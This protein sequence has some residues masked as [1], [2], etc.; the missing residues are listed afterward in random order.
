MKPI[1]S[2][3]PRPEPQKVLLSF[4]SNYVFVCILTLVLYFAAAFPIL[5]STS[6]YL[7]ASSYIENTE[8]AAGFTLKANL[9]YEPYKE[10]CEN[11]YLHSY[12][13][14]LKEAYNEANSTSFT[15]NH[16][17]NILVLRL[18]V[19]PSPSDY[20]TDYF[21]YPL[22]EDGTVNA[23]GLGLI[24]RD[25]GSRG[26]DDVRDIYYTGYSRIQDNLLIFDSTYAK[27]KGD[28]RA[29]EG[30][31]RFACLSFSLLIVEVLFPFFAKFGRRP[32]EL[33][34]KVC[35]LNRNGFGASFYKSLLRALIELLL[36]SIGIYYLN[37]YFVTLFLVFPYFIEGITMLFDEYNRGYIERILSLIPADFK[38]EKIYANEA[39]ML[40]D[41][42]NSLAAYAE[43]GYTGKLSEVDS[44][45]S[46]AEGK[47]S[48]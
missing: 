27:A 30:A 5:H 48:N 22:N 18:P 10:A 33:I 8:V 9:S 19:S 44:F 39:E 13:E 4:L 36:A 14:E 1:R 34:F 47:K 32:G 16:I 7:S 29:M 23:D 31:S 17:Y 21:A 35:Y 2:G 28:I 41:R 42:E 11:F 38:A 6:S 25:L 3:I 40:Q 24:A 43:P 45:S 37:P 26:Y 12:G 46:K 15:L 20:K